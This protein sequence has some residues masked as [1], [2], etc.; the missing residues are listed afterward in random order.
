MEETL[1][2]VFTSTFN[3]GELLA[4]TYESLCRQTLQ[5]FEWLI[6]DDGSTDDTAIRVRV[7]QR[8]APFPIRY[9]HQPN[10]GKHRERGG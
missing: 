3:R 4:R 9:L 2:T 8:S 1:F 7:W 6:I 5:H 10:S